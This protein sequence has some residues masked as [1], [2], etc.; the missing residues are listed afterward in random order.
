MA[1]LDVRIQD[2]LKAFLDEEA[3]RGGYA[4]TSE[5]IEAVLNTFWQ[6]ASVSAIE[7]ELVRRIEGPPAV[8]IPDGFWD[9]LKAKLRVKRTARR[10]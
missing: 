8:E 4:S 9:G 1:S 10:A 5:Y 2:D 7:A 6:N 3:S